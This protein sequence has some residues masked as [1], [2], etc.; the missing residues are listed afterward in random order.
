MVKKDPWIDLRALRKEK[1][2]TQD[3]AGKKLG[4]TRC[5]ISAVELGKR[6]ISLKMMHQ[7]INVFDI[8]YEDFYNG[9][10]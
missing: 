3:E 2:W 9:T 6:N 8:K 10:G 7:I 4:F 1:D 5:Y